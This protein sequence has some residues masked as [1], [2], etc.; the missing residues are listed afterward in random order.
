MLLIQQGFTN[1]LAQANIWNVT[2]TQMHRNPQHYRHMVKTI[3]EGLPEEALPQLKSE[4]RNSEPRDMAATAS[5]PKGM[6]GTYGLRG[7]V[8]RKRSGIFEGKL[9]AWIRGCGGEENVK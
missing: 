1:G 2:S 6:A 8:D 4:T 5:H 3:T 7:R 9:I